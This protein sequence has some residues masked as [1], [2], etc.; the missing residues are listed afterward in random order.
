MLITFRLKDKNNRLWKRSQFLSG[1]EENGL[2]REIKYLS[3]GIESLN[4]I[5]IDLVEVHSIDIK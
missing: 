1:L 3:I 5:Y 4:R 2:I